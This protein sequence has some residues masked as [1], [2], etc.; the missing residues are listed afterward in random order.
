MD[1]SRQSLSS[2][3]RQRDPVCGNA[4]RQRHLSKT[5]EEE[6]RQNRAG[7]CGESHRSDFIYGS[8]NRIIVKINGDDGV[9]HLVECDN[10]NKEQRQHNR[11]QQIR[12][13]FSARLQGGQQQIPD[14]RRQKYGQING[15][16]KVD[17]KNP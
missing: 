13:R 11:R 1:H 16:H 9:R 8:W 3:I 2:G 7:K 6:C 10:Q 12:L 15:K 5:A 4:L 14:Q 17:Q